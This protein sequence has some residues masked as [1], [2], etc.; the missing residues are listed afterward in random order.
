MRQQQ[1]C[2]SLAKVYLPSIPQCLR[3]MYL[4]LPMLETT[5]PLSSQGLSIPRLAGNIGVT[6]S[7]PARV[8]SHLKLRRLCIRCCQNVYAAA[9]AFASC[10]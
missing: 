10:T 3:K 6:G 4:L 2:C 8:Q 1:P 7:E 5:H 9:V